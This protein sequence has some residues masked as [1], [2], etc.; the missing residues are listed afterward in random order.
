MG[1]VLVFSLSLLIRH[2]VGFQ[3][4]ASGYQGNGV[5]GNAADAVAGFRII[6]MF[7]ML[8]TRC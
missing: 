4:R 7:C 8:S 2:Q 1:V 5:R 3:L 6:H